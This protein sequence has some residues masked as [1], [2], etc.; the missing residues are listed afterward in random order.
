M[1]V[2]SLVGKKPRRMAARTAARKTFTTYDVYQSPGYYRRD[3]ERHTANPA[4]DGGLGDLPY[5]MGDVL[6]SMVRTV[7][8]TID[9]DGGGGGGST[10]REEKE[11]NLRLDFPYTINGETSWLLG[12]S[13]ALSPT[14]TFEVDSKSRLYAPIFIDEESREFAKEGFTVETSC[15][16]N[17]DYPQF[18]CSV[19]N[20]Q[21]LGE[22]DLTRLKE[23]ESRAE[24]CPTEESIRELRDEIGKEMT[25]ANRD[26]MV[27][28][29]MGGPEGKGLTEEE[30]DKFENLE[31]LAVAYSNQKPEAEEGNPESA[32][33][34][35]IE[36][37]IPKEE[38]RLFLG[39]IIDFK[40]HP[41]LIKHQLALFSLNTEKMIAMG[42]NVVKVAALAH[43]AIC[44]VHPRHDG[45]GRTARL[46]CNFLLVSHGL[47][48]IC[49][50]PEYYEAVTDDMKRTVRRDEM[51]DEDSPFGMNVIN[52]IAFISAFQFSK[53]CYECGK[54]G[55]TLTCGSC[56][57]VSYC[58]KECQSKNWK[59]HKP[60][61][62]FVKG[63]MAAHFKANAKKILQEAVGDAVRTRRQ[64]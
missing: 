17:R 27:A 11:P 19:R 61:C 49:N 32:R 10:S 14:A 57:Y 63:E 36:T 6:E 43:N 55:C 21:T 24:N 51:T 53:P 28:R 40:T 18:I 41:A 62:N 30:F 44:Y 46:A 58:S 3:D 42:E 8:W 56:K 45:N 35:P 5:S 2:L 33:I 54:V 37:F 47:W 25:E 50:S 52:M 29:K 60:F 1:E 64:S 59:D 38:D 22:D 48:P 39:R 9:Y 7:R 34:F 16:R 12:I 4:D 15:I 13:K 31:R 23:M 26:F 20:A